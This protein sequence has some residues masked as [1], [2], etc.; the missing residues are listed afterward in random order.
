ME[1]ESLG[2]VSK[3]IAARVHE[4]AE[5]IKKREELMAAMCMWREGNTVFCNCCV[6][7][8]NHP[9]VPSKLKNFNRGN[10]GVFINNSFNTSRKRDFHKNLRNHSSIPLH[11][12]CMNK[13][14]NEKKILDDLR[15]KNCEACFAIIMSALEV[16]KNPAS[17]T[18]DFVR[19]NNYFQ[20]LM[21]DKYATKNN[22]SQIYFEC[23]YI[24]RHLNCTIL[25]FFLGK[26]LCEAEL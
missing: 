25:F 11:L 1:I 10:F 9:Y 21:G 3:V 23:R 13:S 19:L 24:E 26:C 18:K 8:S 4:K 5:E 2:S 12:W 22:G 20:L 16:M 14:K 6:S 17:S 15:E 7:Y